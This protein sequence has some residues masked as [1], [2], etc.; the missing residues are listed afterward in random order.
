MFTPPITHCFSLGGEL[1]AGGGDD[2]RRTRPE[3]RAFV[4]P[5]SLSLQRTEEELLNAFLHAENHVVVV[6][7]G[8][9]PTDGP[10]RRRSRK[11]EAASLLRELGEHPLGVCEGGVGL[12]LFFSS[13]SVFS[14][15]LYDFPAAATSHVPNAPSES[16][17]LM[18]NSRCPRLALRLLADSWPRPTPCERAPML[19]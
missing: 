8:D 15:Q 5:S 10:T 18:N 13:P 14:P 6:A 12:S 16:V 2:K 11:L 19:D 9:R 1:T 3:L 4:G 17:A 7:V